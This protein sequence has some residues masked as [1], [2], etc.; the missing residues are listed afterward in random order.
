[1]SDKMPT[2]LCEKTLFHMCY[3]FILYKIILNFIYVLTLLIDVTVI[4]YRELERFE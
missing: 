3:M 2:C 1:M 4:D